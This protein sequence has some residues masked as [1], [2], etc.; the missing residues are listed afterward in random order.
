M[1]FNGGKAL[2][3]RA[4]CQLSLGWVDDAYAVQYLGERDHTWLSALQGEYARFQGFRQSDLKRRLAE[5]LP[6]RAPRVKQRIAQHLLDRLSR[7]PLAVALPPREARQVLFSLAARQG[8]TPG[9]LGEGRAAV[10]AEAA[11]LIQVSP[12][13]LEAALFADLESER[14]VVEIPR[15][16]TP[17]V[18][19]EQAN[20]AI[21]LSLLARARNVSITLPGHA[22]AHPHPHSEPHALVRY[23]RRSGLLCQVEPLGTSGIRLHISG[24]FALFRQTRVYARALTSLAQRVLGSDAF[25]IS[26]ECQL[27]ARG[28]AVTVGIHAGDPIAR[29]RAPVPTETPAERQLARDFRRLT[30]NWELVRDPSP[31]TLGSELV[32]ADFEIWRR[33][34]PERRWLVEVVGFWTEDYLKHKLARLSAAG[35]DRFLLCVDTARGCCPAT[36]P[37]NPRLVPF[38]RRVDARAVLAHLEAG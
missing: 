14:R 30:P 21:A 4:L 28:D 2:L 12:T 37:E 17:A 25:S 16:L 6:V 23:A 34:A 13:A 24:P 11:A 27:A 26:A 7:V 35:F 3:P 15:A 33:E 20:L 31:L 32:F 36:L 10:F 5:P 29:T 1:H 22:H 8:R 9:A 38:R 19:A 18:L